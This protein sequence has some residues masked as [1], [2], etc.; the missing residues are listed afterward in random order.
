MKSSMRNDL[1]ITSMVLAIWE[2]DSPEASVSTT[3]ILSN[4]KKH[5]ASGIVGWMLP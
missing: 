2:Q 4:T 1:C 3:G 5:P